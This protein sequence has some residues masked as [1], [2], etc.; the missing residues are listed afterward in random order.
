MMDDVDNDFDP[1]NDISYGKSNK[2]HEV[3]IVNERELFHKKNCK[4]KINNSFSICWQCKNRLHCNATLLST[5]D[6]VEIE[7]SD[8][9]VIRK[10]EH[11]ANC[12]ISRTDVIVQKYLNFLMEQCKEPGVNQ[13]I[14]YEGVLN[15]LLIHY[16]N[17]SHAFPSYQSLQS[18]M[19]RFSLKHRPRDPTIETIELFEIPIEYRTTLGENGVD[20]I[21]HRSSIPNPQHD[22][23]LEGFI[24]LGDP[25]LINQLLLLQMEPL[26]LPLHP[27][28][29]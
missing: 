20:F 8:Y 29:N 22:N 12:S 4:R 23:R 5:R 2:G 19:S 17:A 24:V 3:M 1:D 27:F 10:R 26:Q 15:H 25:Q 21:I 7:G 6:F 14:K 9:N 16:P 11:S 13:Q 18:V 28:C